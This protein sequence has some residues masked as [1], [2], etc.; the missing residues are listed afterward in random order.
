MRNLIIRESRNLVIRE[1]KE[2]D[3]AD[4]LGI[5]TP[6]VLHGLATFEQAPP[7]VEEMRRRRQSVLQMGLPYL[8]AELDDTVVG[9]AY[10]NNHRPRPAYRNSIENSVYVT[11]EMHGKGIG[12]AL[13]Q[14]LI[15]R[16]ENGRWRQMVAVIGGSENAG[17]IGLHE[18]LGF[19]HVGVL[20]AVGF[21]LGR[22]VDTV[23]MQRPLGDGSKTL[24]DGD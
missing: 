9:Y 10:A 17:S 11:K 7:S 22:W 21:K 13:L 23:M 5:Y 4:I 19:R 20:K 6:E 12:K 16:C 1:S 15:E 14:A 3:L 8:V 2:A 18:N 24:P